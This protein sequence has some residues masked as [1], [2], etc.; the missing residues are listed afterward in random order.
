MQK[1]TI[2]FKESSTPEGAPVGFFE[3]M[4]FILLLLLPFVLPLFFIPSNVF[5]FQFGKMILL[6]VFVLVAF[7]LWVLARL[8]DGNFVL[9]SSILTLAA[10]GILIVTGVSGLFSGDIRWSFIGQS[11]DL[12]TVGALAV[13]VLLLFLVPIVFKTKDRIFYAYL[14]FFASFFIVAFFQILRLVFGV[15]FLSFGIFTNA[16]SNLLGR[17]NDLGV[18]FGI[19]TVLSLITLEL[20]SL[21][22]TFKSLLYVAL[23]ISLFFL[24]AVNFSPVWYI[25]GIFSLIFLVYIVSFDKSEALQSEFSVLENSEGNRS[26]F[27]K[28]PFTSLTVLLI[29]LAFIL[30]GNQISGF[31]IDKLGIGQIQAPPT[32]SDTVSVAK[33]ALSADPILGSGPNKFYG[34][35]LKYK[36]DVINSGPFWNVDFNFAVGLVPTFM[37]TTGIL[38]IIAWLIFLGL[39]LFVGFR[40]I[41]S[42][43]G[44]R[45]SRYLVTSSFLVALFLWVVNLFYVPSVPVVAMTFLFTGL[46]VASSYQGG[47]LKTRTISFVE[48]PRKGFVS[49]MSLILLLIGTVAVGYS[50]V[51]KFIASVYFQKGVVVFNSTGNLDQTENYIRK[52]ISLDGNLAYYYRTLVQIGMMRM[53]SILSQD[54]KGVSIDSLQAQFQSVLSTTLDSA[55]KA[56]DIAPD[57]YQNWISKGQIYEALVPFKEIGRTYESANEAY[58]KALSLNPK[59]PAIFLT[60]ARLEASKGDTLKSKEYIAQA[61]QHRNSY[62]EA[63]FLLSQIQAAEGKIDDAIE[64]VQA[65]SYLSPND[66]GVFFQLGL[67]RYNNKDFKGAVTALERAVAINPSYANAKYFLGLSYYRLGRN[68]DAITQFNDLKLTNPEN[69]EVDLILKNLN[70]GLSPFS[71]ATPPIDSKPEKRSKPP[72]SESS[73]KKGEDSKSKISDDSESVE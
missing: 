11:I 14:L 71:N 52:A 53:S 10:F 1:A 55:L 6:S 46:F 29:S 37:L 26:N 4:A 58:Q 30:A 72:V 13:F 67:L 15:E 64:S 45:V 62:T 34:E 69:G 61:L 43:I 16:S 9:P 38:G 54:P 66:S 49:V 57:D 56:V 12:G 70:A 7:G 28:I 50:Y 48:D 68:K 19:G 8:K 33:G 22:K 41:L 42:T 39:F 51:G 59:S 2:D 35:W 24:A 40:S 5:P 65:A 21:G 63:I 60:F 25:L 73:S 18:F 3:K 44:D 31:T 36:P 17:W 27:R 47:V 23:A 32:W 20:I